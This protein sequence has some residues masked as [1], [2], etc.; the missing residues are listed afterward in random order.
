MPAIFFYI[1]PKVV[2]GY[3]DT[4]LSGCKKETHEP[5]VGKPIDLLTDGKWLLVSFGYDF[6]NSGALED[7]ENL[8]EDCQKD[9]TNQYFADGRGQV[10]DNQATCQSP[11]ESNFEWKFVDNEKAVEIHFQRYELVKLTN[12]ELHF[13]IHLQGISTPAH[14]IYRKL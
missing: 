9:N 8:I 10:R 6:D 3:T 7:P 11:A 5:Q 13:I 1:S 2:K 14:T 4:I 12:T